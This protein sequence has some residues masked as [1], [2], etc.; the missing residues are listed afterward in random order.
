MT[1][2]K[3]LKIWLACGGACGI[4]LVSSWRTLYAQP[5]KA[6]LDY[7]QVIQRSTQSYDLQNPERGAQHVSIAPKDITEKYLPVWKKLF[8]ERN[9]V[10][11]DY[12]NKHIRV[13]ETGISTDRSRQLVPPAERGRE[14]F[15][16]LYRIKVDWVELN[17]GDHLLIRK[18]NEDRYL[19]I[20]EFIEEEKSA[21][22][23]F[24]KISI[25]IP[26]EKAP[27]SFKEAV[28]KLKRINSDAR[29]LKPYYL[30][31]TY[32]GGHNPRVDAQHIEGSGILLYG[33]GVIGFDECN[34]VEG[35]LNLVTGKGY[36][37]RY[38][39]CIE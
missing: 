31:L 28:Q 2:K 30:T 23:T 36:V 32:F 6:T 15:E 14:Y 13:I 34:C 29:Y 10:S 17:N 16:V 3:R 25:F 38:Y 9:G 37:R 18:W 8:M 12:F 19:S 7:Q 1:R 4:I 5:Q 22:K 24:Q 20:D 11:E 27:L 35:Y 39:C 33:K 26:I 21:E